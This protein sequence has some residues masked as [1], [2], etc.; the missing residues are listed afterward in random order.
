M[1]RLS[2]SAFVLGLITFAGICFADSWM[3]PK[4]TV[5]QSK[6]GKLR[7]TVRPP[8]ISGTRELFALMNED[9][10]TVNMAANANTNLRLHCEGILEATN[11]WG[12]FNVLWR[13]PLLNPV[14]PASVL[15]YEGTN[16][17]LADLA[18][19]TFDDWHTLGTS[20]NTVVM[21]SATGRQMSRLALRDL[22]PKQDDIDKLLHTASSV[23]WKNGQRIDETTE[24]VV[25]DIPHRDSVS[26][27]LRT[28]KIVQ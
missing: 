17:H 6:S 16:G 13:R 26:I 14:S 18:V 28:G 15:L 3:P 1:K 24:T 25:L 12:G 10:L 9:Y 19:V 5:Y 21:Y 11:N 27:S 20:S 4:T 8:E 22:L 23:M 2:F 7:F